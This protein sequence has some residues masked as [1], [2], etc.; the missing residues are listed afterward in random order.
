MGPCPCQRQRGRQVAARA[1]RRGG[2]SAPETTHSTKLWAGSQFLTKSSCDP[3]WLTSTRRVTVRDQL[4]RGD[5]WYT[6]DG[7]LAAHQGNWAAGTREVIRCTTH[8]GEC[9]HQAPGHLSCSD[10]GRAE[11]ADP[12]ESVPLW[13]TQKHEPE[14][15]K[16]GKYTQ[17]RAHFRQF[18]CRATWNL[19]SVDWESTHAVNRGKPSVAQTHR[20]LPTH[21]SD[22]CLQF[23]SPCPQHSTTEQARLYKW[24]PLPPCV[25]VEIKHW[26]DLQTEEAKINKEEGT[27]LEVTG[28]ID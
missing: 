22:N 5:T 3:G 2:I 12:T 1:R 25:K 17:P 26:R 23:S 14:Q 6:W 13:S 8:L 21:T 20:T 15:L 11:N 4:P 24:S 19:S 10:L 18:P 27:T 28:A 16:P 7:T 9:A